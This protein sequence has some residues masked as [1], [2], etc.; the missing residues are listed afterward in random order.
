M[1]PCWCYIARLLLKQVNPAM[2]L[3][4][5]LL[6]C[7][8]PVPR[9]LPPC[10]TGD[11]TFTII[12]YWAWIPCPPL[13]TTNC[14]VLNG[15]GVVTTWSQHV[16]PDHHNDNPGNI[17]KVTTCCHGLDDSKWL[18]SRDVCLVHGNDLQDYSYISCLVQLFS[19]PKTNNSLS[20][21]RVTTLLQVVREVNSDNNAFGFRLVQSLTHRKTPGLIVWWIQLQSERKC[22]KCR[23]RTAKN[24][25]CSKFLLVT[26]MSF[27]DH[28]QVYMSMGKCIHQ[29]NTENALIQHPC[30]N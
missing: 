18:P 30:P 16:G 25:R 2:W 3:G 27:W 4:A 29:G 22:I 5:M 9:P 8:E 10:Q 21:T 14:M 12:M 13:H 26:L 6:Q 20:A 23:S 15:I 11:G 28:V 24:I 1:G 17:C 7:S 19:N